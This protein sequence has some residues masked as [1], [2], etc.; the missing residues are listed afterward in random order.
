M[1][2]LTDLRTE[3]TESLTPLSVT[4][5]THVPGRMSLPGAFVMAGS[6]Y[7]EQGDTFGARRIR[8]AVILAVQTGTNQS[9]TTAL[10]ELIES[11][12]TALETDDW[13]V[14]EVSQPYSMAFNN[15]EGLVVEL[16]VTTETNTLT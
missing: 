4:T 8:F 1:S 14:E 11:A 6:P 16:T 9:E 10:D 2:T 3:L 5:Y 12:I 7:I 13:L 15:A